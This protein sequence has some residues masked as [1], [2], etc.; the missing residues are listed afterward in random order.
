[1][2]PLQ[3]RQRWGRA[4]GPTLSAGALLAICIGLAGTLVRTRGLGDRVR[5][6][7]WAISFRPPRGWEAVAP[8][9]DAYGAVVI[10]RSQDSRGHFR[11][12]R[13]SR[14]RNPDRLSPLRICESLLDQRLGPLARFVRSPIGLERR[15]LG[16]LPGARCSIVQ[17]RGWY[18]HVAGLVRDDGVAE[19]YL[20][21]LRSDTP[22][23]QR[24][25]SLGDALAQSVRPAE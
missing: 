23:E 6:D 5:I 25:L 14:Q 22:L 16:H 19:A 17:P 7:G 21:E 3:A 12:V 8:P 2:D 10:Y 9:Q 13:I 24:D 18:L 1:M 15:P 11:E 4:V 20:L